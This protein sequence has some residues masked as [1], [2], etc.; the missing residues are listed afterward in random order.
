MKWQIEKARIE[1][2]QG[3][4]TQQK[5]DA[6]VNAANSRLA[7]GGGVDGAIHCAGGPAI[8]EETARLFSGGCEVG[9]AVVTGAGNLA[10]KY[11]IHTVGP[12]WSD[13]MLGEAG[14]LESAYRQSLELAALRGCK[15]VAFPAISTGAYGY[16]LAEAASIAVTTVAHFLRERQQPELVR[17]VL[18][19]DKVLQAFEGAV[20]GL[21]GKK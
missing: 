1:L 10:A 19:S 18:F 5:V 8:M 6:I 13:G 9:T 20:K 12:M 16:P 15:S 17:F 14:F 3:D 4:I 2:V 11:V 21:K 7:G